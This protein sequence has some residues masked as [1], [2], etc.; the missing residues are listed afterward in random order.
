MAERI[1]SPCIRQCTLDDQD[2]CVGCFRTITEICGWSAMDDSQKVQTIARAQGRRS[3]RNNFSFRS[4][5]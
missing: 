2:V 1:E 3:L 5:P 4:R